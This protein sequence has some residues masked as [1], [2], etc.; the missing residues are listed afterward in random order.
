MAHGHYVFRD[1]STGEEVFQWMPRARATAY[2]EYGM[3]GT[4]PVKLLRKIIPEEELFPPQPGTSWESHHAFNAWGPDRWLMPGVLEEYFG[5]AEDLEALVQNSQLLQC[6]GYK[7]IFEEARRQKPVCAM[8]VNWCYNEPWIT[9]VNNSLLNYP[10]LPKPAFHAVGNSCRPFLASARIPRF[11][12]R[13]GETFSCDLYILND[14]YS[15]IPDGKVTVRLVAG[16]ER[17]ELLSWAFE[18]AKPNRNIT[19][20]TVRAVLPHWDADRFELILEVT[21]HP[22]YSSSYTLLYKPSASRKSRGRARR[23]NQ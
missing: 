6:E 10:N 19:G 1:Q 17:L 22:E 14:M 2:T 18:S 15:D 11:T 3:P 12:W 21:G 7:C 20:P 5:A 13:E 8:A 4:S 9:A 16:E 23:L